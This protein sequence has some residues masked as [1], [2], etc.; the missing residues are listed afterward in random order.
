MVNTIFCGAKDE[1]IRTSWKEGAELADGSFLSIDQNMKVAE[2]AA[3]QDKEIAA[4]GVQLNKTYIA[5]G[6]AGAAGA[7]RQNAQDAN[8]V[9]AAPSANVQRQVAKA[10][11]AYKNSTWDIVDALNEGKVDLDKVPAKDLPKEMQSMSVAERKA[12]VAK[13][14]KERDE[15]QTKIR[16]LDEDRRKYVADQM[17][18]NPPKEG[19]L[20]RAVVSAVRASGTKKGYKFE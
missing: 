9:S 10:S 5:Y 16:K 1:G 19:T 4:L 3:P 7:G 2:I 14:M 13:K 8:A 20:D 15:L 6:A 12:Y 17:K 18:K 11:M